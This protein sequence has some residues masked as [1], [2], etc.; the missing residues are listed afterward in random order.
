V[1]VIGLG[2]VG[3]VVARAA[4]QA[5]MDVTGLDTSD[6]QVAALVDGHSPIGGVTD[7]QLAKMFADGFVVTQN[8]ECVNRADVT[9]ICVPTPVHADG[10]PDLTHVLD[11]GELIAANLKQGTL[12]VLESTTYPGTT[13]GALRSVLERS[14]LQAGKDFAL[15]YSPERI[16]LG[17][18]AFPF[19][20]IPK[21]VSGLTPNCLQSASDFYGALVD[22]V[23][24]TKDLREAEMAKL[25]E[26]TYR[27]VNIALVNEV[28][29]F[30]DKVGI[31]VWEVIRA[32]SSKPFGFQ[33]FEPGPGVGGHC[34]PVDPHY[35]IYSAQSAGALTELVE[36]A[37]RINERMPTHIIDRVV[38]ILDDHDLPLTGAS[39]LLLGVTFKADV[40]D[41]RSSSAVPLAQRLLE[42]GVNVSFHDPFVESWRVGEKVLRRVDLADTLRTADLVVV[43]Q[44]HSAYDLP[45]IQS[46]ARRLFDTRGR[47]RGARTVRL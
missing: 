9:V 12:V 44:H 34:I 27:M 21:V 41:H 1:V 42:I 2:Y 37:L 24:V 26:N 8:P 39:V 25:L 32:A 47:L 31:D 19:E 45:G 4:I 11:A 36:I 10:S 29:I 13:G 28:A 30:C 3:L 22:R 43:L 15:A 40:A 16:D 17:N 46:Q 23:V 38:R 14:G 35:L 7:T 20:N 33:P 6:E 5:G 18:N